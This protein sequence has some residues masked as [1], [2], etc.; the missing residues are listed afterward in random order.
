MRERQTVLREPKEKDI[1]SNRKER[2]REEA[3]QG[4]NN[5]YLAIS[6]R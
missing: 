3:N 2:E 1:T 4:Y 5:G 6:P